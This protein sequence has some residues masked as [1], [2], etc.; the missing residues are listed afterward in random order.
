MY[1]DAEEIKNAN[2]NNAAEKM[3]AHGLIFYVRVRV[4]REGRRLE[5]V[6]AGVQSKDIQ[7]KHFK[8]IVANLYKINLSF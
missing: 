6:A 3:M 1:K 7:K 5:G 4:Q 8:K 2:R